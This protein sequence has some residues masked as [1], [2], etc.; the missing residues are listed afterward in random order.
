MVENLAD[1]SKSGSTET[2]KMSFAYVA[3]TTDGR[4]MRGSI[5]AASLDVAKQELERLG[6]SVVEFE[7]AEKATKTKSFRGDDFILFNQQLAQLTAAGLPVER[8]LRLIARDMG[9]GRLAATVEQIAQELDRGTPLEDAFDRHRGKFPSMYGALMEAGVRSGNL[10]GMLLNLGRHLEMIQRLRAALWRAMSYPL[11]LLLSTAG[12]IV[13]L[14]YFVLPGFFTIF[15]DFDVELPGIT[16]FLTDTA[17]WMPAIAIGVGVLAL[18]VPI[19]AGILRATGKD[20]AFIDAFLVPLPL[21]GR[22]LQHN[23]AA[24]WCDALQMAISAGLDL[25]K[26][27]TLAGDAVGSPQLQRDGKQLVE[28]IEQGRPLGE[29]NPPKS[30]PA[31][32]IAAIDLSTS[33]RDLPH[34]LVTIAKM[35]EEQAEFRVSSVQ[36]FTAPFLLI[37]MSVIMGF[38][39]TALFMPLVKLIQ[40]VG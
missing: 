39:I 19:I 14:S 40:S 27:I 24:R 31:T 3:Q 22:V 12:L 21:I 20:Q 6:L 38:V 1:P 16:V 5:D 26:A 9:N 28:W 8:G 7:P 4:V 34:A 2:E 37:G 13:F 10:P 30:I 11:L 35:Y 32:V 33:H 15:E 29:F 23:R 17:D 36:L 25:P 18:S